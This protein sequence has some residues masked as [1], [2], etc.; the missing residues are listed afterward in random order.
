MKKRL[1]IL[2][3]IFALG[4]FVMPKQ[5]L[6]AQFEASAMACCST[7]NSDDNCHHTSEQENPCK[8]SKQPCSTNCCTTCSSCAY[9]FTPLAK[10][11]F[12][13]ILEA[14]IAIEKKS[15]FNYE[16]P[17]FSTYLKDIWQPPK[18]A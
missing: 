17:H 1:Q 14:L 11:Q 9:G 12:F 6:L 16:T 5:M 7:S 10:P 3:M 18:I 2:L 8:D 4:I 15:E 13:L